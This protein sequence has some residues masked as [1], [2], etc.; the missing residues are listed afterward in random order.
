MRTWPGRST[1][2]GWARPRGE[3]GPRGRPTD[4]GQRLRVDGTFG[5]RLI[6]AS[7]SCRPDP[8]APELSTYS[9]GPISV[10]YGEAGP[11]AVSDLRRSCQNP[12]QVRLRARQ[13]DLEDRPMCAPDHPGDRRSAQCHHDGPTVPIAVGQTAALVA[14]TRTY[15]DGPLA[16]RPSAGPTT[17]AG[18]N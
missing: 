17:P 12:S 5:P 15:I 3:Q 2:Q 16:N 4:P 6:F 7:V 8:V 13:L 9:R 18:R 14:I 10:C 1:W 11:V